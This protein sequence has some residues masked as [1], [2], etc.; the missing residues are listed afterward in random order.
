[1]MEAFVALG[2]ASNIVQFVDFTCKLLASTRAIHRFGYDHS[3]DRIALGK[4]ANDAKAISAR[5]DQHAAS[6]DPD[7]ELLS[8]ECKNIAQDLLE[9]LGKLKLRKDKTRWAS[10]ALALKDVAKQRQVTSL[11]ERLSKVQTQLNSH[12]QHTLL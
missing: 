9:M 7:L 3:P 4:I 6:R 2:L 10:F 11:Y 1:M 12:I 8:S 5:L